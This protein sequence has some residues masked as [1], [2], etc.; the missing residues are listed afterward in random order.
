[1]MRRTKQ[2]PGDERL[3]YD[4]SADEVDR[5]SALLR[6]AADGRA[7]LVS[8]AQAWLTHDNVTLRAEGINMLLSFWRRADA[9]PAALDLLHHDPEP[10]VRAMA[11][12]ALSSFVKI[13]QSDRDHILAELVEQLEREEDPIV[14]HSLYETLLPHVAPGADHRLPHHFDRERDVNW[15]LLR[16]WR[17]KVN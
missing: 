10:D 3:L 17:S 6:L 14:Q 12:G 5:A 7:D 11:A 8:V 9:V 1:M 2:R 15:E 13:T 4:E 16:P